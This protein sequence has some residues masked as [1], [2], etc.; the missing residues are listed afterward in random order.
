MA[1]YLNQGR[2]NRHRGKSLERTVA[3]KLG[4]FRV[5]YSGQTAS[6]GRGD[7]TDSNDPRA[8]KWV[9][10]CK[11]RSTTLMVI[12]GEWLDELVKIHTST[13]KN[14][15]LALRLYGSPDIWMCVPTQFWDHTNFK[16][17]PKLTPTLWGRW[18]PSKYH[19]ILLDNRD[20]EGVQ[21]STLHLRHDKDHQHPDWWPLWDFMKVMRIDV[22]ADSKPLL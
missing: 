1:D 16:S 17:L 22:F 4:F 7:V 5:P 12:E 15:A 11:S 20:L 18:S 14:V 9:I 13:G 8:S 10:E 2:K 21:M 3:K 19:N 6:F